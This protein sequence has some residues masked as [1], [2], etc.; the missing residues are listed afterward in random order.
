MLSR[1]IAASL[2]IGL[3]LSCGPTADGLPT[4]GPSISPIRAI[5]IVGNGARMP[6]VVRTGALATFNLDV[7]LEDAAGDLHPR[8][9]Q[10]VTWGSTNPAVADGGDEPGAAFIY[11]NRNG[12]AKIIAHLDGMRDTVAFQIAQVAVSG[13][14]VADTVVTLASDARDLSGA[15]SAYHAFR[16]ATVRV[17]SNGYTVRSTERLQFDAGPDAPF[18]VVP[19]PLGD[20][21][22]V[23]GTRA[24]V[25]TLVTR[26]G[27]AADTITVQVADAYRVVRL[28]ETPSGALRTFPDTVQIPVGTAVIFQNETRSFLLIDSFGSER[29]NWR[30]GPLQPNGRQAQLFSKAGTHSYFWNGGEAFIIVTP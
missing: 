11:L 28:I 24:G 14:L 20:T 8:G 30:V 19:E 4:E 21:I 2:I 3:T 22:A 9:N 23:L 10:R 26:L 17:D 7:E 1:R 25:G 29:V 16:Y 15:L 27:D 13:R 12:E 5:H 18:E 6:A